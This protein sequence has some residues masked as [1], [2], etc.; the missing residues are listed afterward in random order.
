MP[1]IEIKT[2]KKITKELEAA[3]VRDFGQAIETFSGKTEKYLMVNIEGECGMAFAGVI[4]DCCMV[5]VD[6]LGSATPEAYEKMTKVTC[7]LISRVLGIPEDRV[8][9]KYSEYETWGWNG[10]NF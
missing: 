6:L 3:L 10:I 8:Y 1:F 7:T 9:V 4:G 2:D 5:S